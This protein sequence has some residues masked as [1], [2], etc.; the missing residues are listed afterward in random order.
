VRPRSCRCLG[1]LSKI[2]RALNARFLYYRQ[3]FKPDFTGMV[4][5]LTTASMNGNHFG[6]S[7]SSHTQTRCFPSFWGRGHIKVF[8]LNNTAWTLML[9]LILFSWN[10]SPIHL[11]QNGSQPQQCSFTSPT[12]PTSPLSLTD[13]TYCFC[14]PIDSSSVHIQLFPGV[15]KTWRQ[16]VVITSVT[17]QEK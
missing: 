11:H 5:S 12:Y 6:I 15:I 10:E 17:V 2:R 9:P 7:S 13:I 14:L 8:I 3:V 16:K 1:A 4:S